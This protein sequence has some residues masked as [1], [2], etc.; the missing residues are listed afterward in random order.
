MRM[1]ILEYLETETSNELP[2]PVYI[3]PFMHLNHIWRATQ[4][5]SQ[6]VVL[7]IDGTSQI[8]LHKRR[9]I[10]SYHAQYIAV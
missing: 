5:A 4:K 1:R 10:A 3:I 8:Q 7:G 6:S 2:V 9:L